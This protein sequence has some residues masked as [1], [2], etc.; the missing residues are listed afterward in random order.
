MLVLTLLYLSF[1]NCY[2]LVNNCNKSSYLTL[3]SSS[4][5]PIKKG[6]PVYLNLTYLSPLQINDGLVVYQTRFNYL[7]VYRH[8]ENIG[9]ILRGFQSKLV[10]YPIP[11]YIIGNIFVEIR[12][13]SPTYGNLLCVLIEENF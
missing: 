6:R 1:Y 10:E 9:L 11:S 3:L 2:A 8:S 7:P 4:L 13:S 5:S 12:W